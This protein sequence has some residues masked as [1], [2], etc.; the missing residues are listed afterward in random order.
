MGVYK[1]KVDGRELVAN[2]E[3]ISANKFKVEVAGK[4]VEVELESKKFELPEVKHVLI[5]EFH[6]TKREIGKIQSSG[7]AVTATIPGTV[8]KL[9]VSEGEK[10]K[11]G[12]PLLILE[13]MKMENEIVSPK[14]G[15][16]KEIRVREG[17][18]VETG[19][20]LMVID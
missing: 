16:V 6:E 7:N 8:V 3:R 17:E 2:V 18:R 20:V 5:H 14:D 19:Q 13:A 11:L 1:V 12:D 9:L 10:V 4:V 15:V